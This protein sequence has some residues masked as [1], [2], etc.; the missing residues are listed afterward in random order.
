MFPG[1]GG[2]SR[3]GTAAQLGRLCMCAATLDQNTSMTISSA[4]ELPVRKMAQSV[5]GTME[6]GRG[7]SFV[8][9]YGQHLTPFRPGPSTPLGTYF[10]WI[11]R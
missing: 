4:D 9:A 11:I 5:D 2:I 7:S 8:D 3:A 1:L 6:M 10:L